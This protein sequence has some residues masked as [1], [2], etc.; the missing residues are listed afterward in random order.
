MD[1]WPGFLGLYG[2]NDFETA[3]GAIDAYNDRL[4]GFKDIRMVT[5]Y[6]FGLASA[7]VDSYFAEETDRFARKVV[8]NTAPVSNTNTTTYAEEVCQAEPVAM[9][10]ATQSVTAVP[11]D[12]VR[13][14][15]HRVEQVIARIWTKR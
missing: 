13:R 5:G 4:R 6:H 1:R 9:D 3:D 15:N 2:T 10:L 7:E 14:A 12:V 11:S 8:F